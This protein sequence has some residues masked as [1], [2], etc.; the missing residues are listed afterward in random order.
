[1]DQKIEYNPPKLIVKTPVIG[2]NKFRTYVNLLVNSDSPKAFNE[3]WINVAGNVYTPVIVI[4]ADG[5]EMF[6]VPPIA[7]PVEC[8][9]NKIYEEISSN[10]EANKNLGGRLADVRMAKTLNKI[11][12]KAIQASHDEV[13]AHNESVW[14]MILKELGYG[15]DIL[16]TIP[17]ETD[18]L[19][20]VKRVKKVIDD[21]F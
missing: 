6:R 13:K 1:M 5:V 16:E 21:D 2:I 4:N 9:D 15:E 19:V 17:T 3:S 10:H 8:G 12:S 18:T 11:D 14:L 7:V 20:E